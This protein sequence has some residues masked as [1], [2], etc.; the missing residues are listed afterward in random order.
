MKHYRLLPRK[1]YSFFNYYKELENFLQERINFKEILKD[2]N[3]YERGI[4]IKKSVRINIKDL[5]LFDVG[6]GVF[7][8]DYTTLHVTNDPKFPNG[9][10]GSCLQIGEKTFIGEFN[11]IRAAGG[12]VTIGKK[13]L[14]SQFVSIVA[15]NH[16]IRRDKPIC[17]QPWSTKK[18]NVTIED[19]V[20]IGAGATILPGST[21]CKGAVIG[22]NSVVVGVIPEYAI[23]VG[24]PAKVI[25][26]RE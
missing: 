7:I 1:F 20:W 12:I 24:S 10:Q 22:A 2:I 25:R 21:I 17:E 26:Y 23:A 13:C 6:E 5:A 16:G 15:S 3:A 11:N 14:I 19:D 9:F 18:I 4:T 8:D